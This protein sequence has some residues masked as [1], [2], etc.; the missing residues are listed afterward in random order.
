MCR[1]FGTISPKPV[2]AGFPWLNAPHSLLIQSQIDKKRPQGDGWGTAWYENG[3]PRQIKFPEPVYQDLDR[4]KQA[5]AE[6]KSTVL[7]GH[8][9]WASN[10]LKLAKSELIGPA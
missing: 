9:R 3:Q 1:L 4:L 2:S 10:P 7:L 6:V 5:V 8:V